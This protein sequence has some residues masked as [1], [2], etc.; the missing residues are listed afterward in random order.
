MVKETVY[1][2]AQ[3]SIMEKVVRGASS[4]QLCFAIKSRDGFSAYS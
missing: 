1:E 2:G 3:E 4:W